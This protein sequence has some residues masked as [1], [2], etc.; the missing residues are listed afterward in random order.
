M[1]SRGEK[2]KIYQDGEA[3]TDMDDERDELREGER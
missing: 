3:F 2:T 1:A